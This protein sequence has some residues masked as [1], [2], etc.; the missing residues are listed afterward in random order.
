MVLALLGL[1]KVYQMGREW[2]WALLIF[3]ILDVYIVSSWTCWW[4]AGGSFSSRSMLP[5]YTLFAFPLAYLLEWASRK[6]WLTLVLGTLLALMVVLNLFQSWQWKVGIISKERMTKEY[7]WRVFGRTMVTESD[8]QYLS[9]ERSIEGYD[10]LKNTSGY[11][12]Y[13]LYKNAFV[14]DES[15]ESND[16]LGM[17]LDPQQ[18]FSPGPDITYFD[19]TQSD[20]AWIQARADVYIPEGY[21]CNSPVLVAT[22]HHKGEAYA[23]KAKPLSNES[24]GKPG[25]HE[26]KLDYLTPEVRKVVDNLKVYVWQPDTCP[27][28]VKSLEVIVHEPL[29]EPKS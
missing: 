7:Y 18:P 17:I 24:L 28:R 9:V 8:R 16:S 2:F 21:S 5:A 13:V 6:R 26:L 11:S 20:H 22:F 19:L 10:E 27:V 25:Y 4:Y 23:Y 1:I 29:K 3:L 15:Q 14:D 12:S